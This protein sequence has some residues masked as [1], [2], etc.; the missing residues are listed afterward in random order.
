MIPVHHYESCTSTHDVARDLASR[1]CPD[2]TLVVAATQTAGR[3]RRGRTWF[4]PP[5]GNVYLSY[6]HYS[7]VDASH[8]AGLTLDAAIAVATA[9]EDLC[10]LRPSLKWPNDLLAEDER[11]LG[12][13]LTEL[14]TDLTADGSPVA[15]VGVGLNVALAE[16]DVPEE[17]RTIASSLQMATGRTEWDID[18]VA[19]TI[20]R[21]LREKLSG[22][23]LARAPDLVAWRARFPFVGRL[24]HGPALGDGVQAEIRAVDEDGGLVVRRV[25]SDRDEVV[26]TGELILG[27]RA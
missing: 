6:V 20:G 16:S 18:E 21:R 2:G 3:G 17:L 10:G 9:I 8:I 25:G 15:I 7:H 1:G 13:V 24:V 12:G 19:V 23:E 14:H 22:F 4:S 27:K 11:K 5:T 26:H